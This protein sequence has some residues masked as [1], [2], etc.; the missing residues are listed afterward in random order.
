MARKRNNQDRL[1]APGPVS[2][3]SSVAAAAEIVKSKGGGGKEGLLSFV[4]PT[5]FVEL[6]SRGK[7]YTKDHPLHNKDVVEIRFM[8]AKHEDILTSP[9]LLRKGIAVD[10]LIEDLIIDR[11]YDIDSLL[12]GDKNAITIAARS[13][14]YGPKYSVNM[15]CPSCSVT[16]IQEFDLQELKNSFPEEED[17]K[18]LNIVSTERGTFMVTLPVTGVEVELK[19]LTGKDDKDLENYKKMLKKHAG[20]D[21]GIGLSDQLKQMIVAANG[22]T[23]RSILEQFVDRM[24]AMDSK[25]IRI[26]YAAVMPNVNMK[27]D[28]K[29]KSCG[30]EEEV[31]VPLTAEFFWPSR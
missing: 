12:I 22:E 27:Q 28:F 3:D 13:T 21:T 19:L 15:S 7:F 16:Q 26:N 2:D 11:E 24:P 29:C 1:A 4:M 25:F 6:P 10:R 30:Y 14:G 18:D 5:E 17:L 23:D 8:T 9:T 31:D 20:D